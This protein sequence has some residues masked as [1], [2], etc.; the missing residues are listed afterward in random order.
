MTDQSDDVKSSGVS[1]LS[2]P[3]EWRCT[4][5]LEGTSCGGK[6]G[7]SGLK[8]NM[9]VPKVSATATADLIPLEKSRVL[10][11]PCLGINFKRTYNR[12]KSFNNF[13]DSKYLLGKCNV[14]S[15]NRVASVVEFCNIRRKPWISWQSFKLL[16]YQYLNYEIFYA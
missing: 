4:W 5:A 15:C 16:T 10:R 7:R 1:Y 2:L 6:Q 8:V 12:L 11:S 14:K 3:L 13:I 9:E